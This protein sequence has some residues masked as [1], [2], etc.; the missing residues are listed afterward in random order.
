M[1]YKCR[2]MMMMMIDYDIM[3]AMLITAI[4]NLL[5]GRKKQLYPCVYY[6]VLMI[7]VIRGSSQR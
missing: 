2:M 4:F 3:T 6:I 5:D 1:H 7:I